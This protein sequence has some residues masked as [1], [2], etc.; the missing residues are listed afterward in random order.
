RARR[1]GRIELTLD[2]GVDGRLMPGPGTL[3]L[4]DGRVEYR[5][6]HRVSVPVVRVGQTHERIERR[7]APAV[8]L[9]R[10]YHGHVPVVVVAVSWVARVGQPIPYA[11]VETGD[12]AVEITG[13]VGQENTGPIET[14]CKRPGVFPPDNWGVNDRVIDDPSVLMRPVHNIAAA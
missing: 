9:R 4:S 10:R 3:R 7:I 5:I 12:R 1:R 11:R 13:A 8:G 6:Q 2:D 14:F